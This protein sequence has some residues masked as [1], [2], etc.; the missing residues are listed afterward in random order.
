[1]NQPPYPAC[2]RLRGS[3]VAGR[4]GDLYPLVMKAKDPVRTLFGYPVRDWV[5]IVGICTSFLAGNVWIGG[6]AKGTKDAIT[7]QTQ[8]IVTS[9]TQLRSEIRLNSQLAQRN[10]IKIGDMEDSYN[11]MSKRMDSL[12]STLMDGLDNLDGYFR[13]RLDELRSSPTRPGSNK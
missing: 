2:L 1:M 10:S 13:G 12:Y 4:V 11:D 6:T 7:D 8:A 5:I 9:L 3:A